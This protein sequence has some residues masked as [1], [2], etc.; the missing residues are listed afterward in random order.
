M[1][2]NDFDLNCLVKNVNFF[3]LQKESYFRLDIKLSE[4]NCRK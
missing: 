1:H 4:I 2:K 3:N